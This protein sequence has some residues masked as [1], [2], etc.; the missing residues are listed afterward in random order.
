MR[1]ITVTS[2]ALIA[3]VS[4]C[5]IAAGQA[6]AEYELGAGQPTTT[7]TPAS[8]FGKGINGVFDS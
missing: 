5:L 3:L 4:G 6:V 2:P 1:W 7:T 8:N